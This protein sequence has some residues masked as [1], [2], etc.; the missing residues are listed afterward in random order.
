[1]KS[2]SEMQVLIS[3]N[4]TEKLDFVTCFTHH[5]LWLCPGFDW[6]TVFEILEQINRL[7]NIEEDYTFGTLQSATRASYRR[8]LS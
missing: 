6:R 5:L 7:C 1:M 3:S 4:A 8:K 2:E